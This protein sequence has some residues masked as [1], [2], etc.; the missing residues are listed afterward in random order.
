M[1]AILQSVQAGKIRSYQDENGKTWDSAIE[2]I[3]VVGEV[4]VQN[5]GLVSDQQADLKHHG[6][7]DKAVLAYSCD[8]FTQWQD[9]FPE[10]SV[11][12]GCFG[13][14]LTIAGQTESD[15]CIGDVFQIGS[16]QLQISQPRQPCWKLARKHDIDKL[17]V[18]VQQLGWTGWYFR[19]LQTGMI[20]AGDS[21]ELVERTGG[22]VSV[23]RANE[24]MYAKP[25]NS[26]D[27]L[28]LAK[29]PQLSAA[30]RDDLQKRAL[31]KN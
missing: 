2:K 16:C 24:I 19:V 14:N 1:Q 4:E 5:D 11:V 27:D 25:R 30:W 28:A 9:E 3:P 8:H 7:I 26:G 10:W 22:N 17:A 23:Q 15:V 13:E 12:A 21:I 6:G 18:R 29:C 20:Q 31:S